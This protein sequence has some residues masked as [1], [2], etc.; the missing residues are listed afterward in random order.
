MIDGL[1][2]IF[3]RFGFVFGG[4][5]ECCENGTV[6]SLSIVQ[7]CSNNMLDF[8]FLTCQVQMRCLHLVHIAL[9]YR[10]EVFSIDEDYYSCGGV[11]SVVI[12]GGISQCRLALICIH[13]FSL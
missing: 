8:F 6:Y 10:T 2:C 4:V 13:V 7:Q 1:R 5:V 3:F 9:W 12:Y 11:K